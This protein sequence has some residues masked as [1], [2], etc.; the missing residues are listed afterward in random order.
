M[1]TKKVISKKTSPDNITTEQVLKSFSTFL[2]MSLNEVKFNL[3][4][5]PLGIMGNMAQ[6]IKKTIEDPLK[7][8][9]E[10]V[11]EINEFF[12]EIIGDGIAQV[13]KQN[14]SNIKGLFKAER[15]DNLLY[16]AILLKSDNIN[17]R[18]FI[19]DV[20]DEYNNEEFSD[21]FPLIIQDIPSELQKEFIENEVEKNGFIKIF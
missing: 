19:Y 6:N 10:S 13:I 3:E 5:L 11:S 20:M 16:Y 12:S 21:K 4:A 17:E 14:S 9:Y 7:S 1:S 18:R 2:K 8:G 15:K